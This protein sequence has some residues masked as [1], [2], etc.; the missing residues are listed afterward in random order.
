M[1][2]RFSKTSM[3]T[4]SRKIVAR[5]TP[6]AKNFVEER[7]DVFHIAVRARAEGGRAN[8]AAIEQLARHLAVPEDTIRLIS[9]KTSRKKVFSIQS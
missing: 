3:Q 2:T 8:I 7:G 4:H 1:K 5:V 9:G 6:C